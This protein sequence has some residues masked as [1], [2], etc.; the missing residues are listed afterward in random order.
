MQR[1]IL[2]PLRVLLLL[3]L[4]FLLIPIILTTR[5]PDDDG[6]DSDDDH[7]CGLMLPSPIANMAV[8][9]LVVMMIL[10]TMIM[11]MMTSHLPDKRS[12]DYGRHQS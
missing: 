8:V 2:L 4:P 3:R 10:M 1:L 6:D 11:I 7:D 9:L 5:A 12:R